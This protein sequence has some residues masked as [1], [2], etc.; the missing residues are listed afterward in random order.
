M[1]SPKGYSNHK[2]KKNLSNKHYQKEYAQCM[3]F[4]GTVEFTLSGFY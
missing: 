2:K 4:K 1:Y 3:Q